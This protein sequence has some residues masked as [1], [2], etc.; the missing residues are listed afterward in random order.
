MSESE[1]EATPEV[2]TDADGDVTL[3]D[4]DK[5]MAMLVHLLGAFTGFLGPL[6]IWLMKKDSS[7]F[8]DKEGK[9][10]LN[11][12]ITLI[13]AYVGLMILSVIA[14]K[15]L[16]ILACLFSILILVMFVGNFVL[17]ILGGLKAKEGTPY[18]YPFSL[19]LLS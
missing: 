3:S 6:I 13:I 18:S 14:S 4:E 17:C 16:G 5:T 1:N 7:A 12:Q 10:A 8:I 15:I 9:T 19:K 11:W 2:N